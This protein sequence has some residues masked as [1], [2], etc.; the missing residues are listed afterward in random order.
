MTNR[1]LTTA[2]GLLLAAT[3][4][5]GGMFSV[6]KPALAVMD[7]CYMT[8]IRYGVTAL[9]LLGA[10][11]MKEGRSALTFEGH[12]ARIWGLGALG[13]A[14][15]NL[16]AFT[17]LTHTRPEH[18]AVIMATMPMLTILL[19]WLLKGTR[20][21]AFTLGTVV[22]AFTGVFLV[23]TRGHPAHAFSGGDARWDLLFLAGA[24][25][26]VSYTMGGALFPNWSPL[27]YTALSCSL[28][29][30]AIGAITLILTLAGELKL[31]T[32]ATVISLHWTFAY[33]IVLGGLVAVLSWNTGIRRMGA[34]N[35]VLFINFVPITAFV[36]GLF[37]GHHFSLA[38]LSGAGL[39]IGAL[40]ANNLHLRV[41]ERKA[42]LRGNF[43][44]S[45]VVNGSVSLAECN[46]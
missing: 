44:A 41:I 31:P 10:L 30:L 25:C 39:V 35:G 22:V 26:W 21:H 32:L 36:I 20:P 29:A 46:R 11:A 2:I 3:L 4:S 40:V 23:V 37:Q 18:G 27:R 15:F 1:Q 28:G 33:L 13:F 8:L 42:S 6:A 16:L 17:G 5:W 19:S 9:L 24:L 38:E 7:P 45:P 12:G 34:V 14:G 43:V